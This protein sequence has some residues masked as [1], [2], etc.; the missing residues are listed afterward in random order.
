MR[1]VVPPVLACLLVAL[2]GLAVPPA[3]AQTY[4]TRPIRVVVPF[5]AGGG[6]DIVARLVGKQMAESM[7]Q[8]VVVENRPGA[9]GIVGTDALA[10]AAPDG[11]TIGMVGTGHTINPAVQAK[12]PYDTLADFAPITPVVRLANFLVVSSSFP[13]KTV[14][15]VVDWAKRH[16]G[17]VTY[18]SGGI[19]TAQHVFPELFASL[20]GTKLRHVPYKG[21]APAMNDIIAG[22]VNLMFVTALEAQAHV[23]SG[24]L[25]ALAVT[26]KTR[27]PAHPTVP[28]FVEAGVP[29]YEGDTWFALLAP[30]QT[31]APLVARLNAEVRKAVQRPE[32]NA[33]FEEQG[34]QPF[35]L[36]PSEFDR[37]LR[38]QVA[39]WKRLLPAPSNP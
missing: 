28:T 36:A 39:T 34:A 31:P 13:P 22:H 37:Y 11:Y 30:A 35:L 33:L 4:P 27:L 21:G 19:G 29:G 18:A 9:G 12:L 14:A 15:E 16:P 24:R 6:Q 38:E 5:A 26:G 17:E 32:V 1:R 2:L 20:T 3:S 25:R 8:P 23:A 7:G 10:K